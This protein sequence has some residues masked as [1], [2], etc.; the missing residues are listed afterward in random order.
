M[1]ISVHQYSSNPLYRHPALG[2]G[3]GPGYK[4][5]FGY[6]LVGDDY[7]GSNLPDR[8]PIPTDCNGHGTHVT[9]IIGAESPLFTGVA[10]GAILGMFRV[11]GCVGSSATDVIIEAFI[12]AYESGGK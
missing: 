10:P 6:D 9:G 11:F 12:D 8:D 4:I 1:L 2:G 7:T 5:Q 3:F